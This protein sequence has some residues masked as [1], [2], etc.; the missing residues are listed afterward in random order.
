MPKQRKKG[1]LKA[2]DGDKLD[3]LAKAL[4]DIPESRLRAIL[5][6][7][8]AFTFR[9]SEMDR[10]TMERAAKAMSISVAEYLIRLHYHA[11]DVLKKAG[12]TE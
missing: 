10:E 7:D 2:S 5:K 8:K 9:L 11:Y 1:V 4:R 12:V 3:T 6:R